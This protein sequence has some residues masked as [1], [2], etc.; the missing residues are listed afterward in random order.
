MKSKLFYQYDKG[1]DV[2]Y[3]S[4]GKPSSRDTSKETSD[5]VILR[6]DPKSKRVKGF[7]ILNFAGRS[8]KKGAAISLPIEAELSATKK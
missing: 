6:L 5:D 4:Q 3:F 7:T 1:A 8:G 2:L